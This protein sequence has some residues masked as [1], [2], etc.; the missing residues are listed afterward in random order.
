MNL[1]QR[2]NH[3]NSG[4][5]FPSDTLL[6]RCI[7]S[8]HFKSLQLIIQSSPFFCF[9]VLIHLCLGAFLEAQTM[10]TLPVMQETQVRSLGSGRSPGEGNGNPLH[11]RHAGPKLPNQDWTCA[12]SSGSTILTTGP[13]G[14]SPDKGHIDLFFLT[15][16]CVCFFSIVAKI[17][18]ALLTCEILS[19]VLTSIAWLWFQGQEHDICY[20]YLF[21]L[22][23]TFETLP[24]DT[25]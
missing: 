23:N 2:H 6:E 3:Q 18:S 22:I 14:K 25:S 8:C 1:F 19:V 7:N 5:F 13:P 15:S 4:H 24:K 9:L 10:K 20:K 21:T 16:Y 12:P 17:L 11:S